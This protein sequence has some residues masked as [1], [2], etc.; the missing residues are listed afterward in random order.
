MVTDVRKL[1]TRLRDFALALPEATEA[2]PWGERVAKVNKKVFVFLG[3]DMDTHFGFSV[4]LPTS[5]AGALALP[6]TEPTGYGLGKSGWVSAK[7]EP[8]ARVSFDQLRDWVLESYC[9]VAPKTLA[10]RVRGD[11]AAS[12]KPVPKTEA[13]I[14]AKTA[15]K[16]RAKKAATRTARGSTR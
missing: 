6:F 15:A 7:L 13:K 2:L 4:K 10:A 1:R 8:G 3:R 11:S 5:R 16:P 12:S 9:A 14:K